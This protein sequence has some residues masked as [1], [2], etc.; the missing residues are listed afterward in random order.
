MRLPFIAFVFFLYSFSYS[1]TYKPFDTVSVENRKVF[2]NEYEIR[3]KQ[4]L[5]EVKKAFSGKI[6]EQIEKAYISQFEDISRATKYKELYFDANMQSYLQNILLEITLSNPI[7]QNQNI[8][9]YF[10]RNTNP[11]AFS[12]GDGTVVVNTELLKYIDDEAE[13]SFV[14]CHEIAHFILNHRDSSIQEYVIKQ[15]GDEVKKAEKDIKKS[16]FN[17][18]SKSE[19]LAQATIYSKKYRSRTQEFQADSLG[20]AYFK[21]MKYN[22]IASIKLL[23][24]LSETDIE[25]DSLPQKSYPKYFTT[26]N[27]KFLKE[28]LVSEDYSKYNY[29]K[30]QFFKW[31]VDSL[32]THPDCEQRIARIKPEVTDNKKNYSIDKAFFDELKKRIAFEQVFN[33]YYMEEYGQSLYET[34][35]LREKASNDKFLIQMTTLNLEALAKA[36]KEL[37]YNNYIPLINP[38]EQTKSQ[39]YF[40]NFMSNLTLTEIQNLADDYKS[41]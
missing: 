18:Q 37:K 31:N 6:S 35:K 39:Q 22:N 32:K 8:R 40:F 30:E 9:V 4:K 11:N 12:I 19:K 7:L 16:K 28:W 10:S 27:Q 29:S 26:K 34:L 23:K 33:Y 25:L 38:K 5:K 17:K 36:K 1:Q 3:H 20:L 2:L 41:I 24:N 15:N 13:L 21:K 14:I